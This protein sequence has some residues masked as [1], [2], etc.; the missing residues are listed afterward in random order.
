MV[1][2]CEQVWTEISNYLDGEVEAGLRAAIDEHIHGCT[3]CAAVLEGTR[4]VIQLYGDER[5]SEVPL[6]FGHRLHRRLED[7]M[8]SSRRGFLGWMVAAAAA[9]LLAGTFELARSSPADR[10]PL[11]SEHAESG[12]GVPPDMMVVVATDGK[13]FHRNSRCPFINDKGHLRTIPAH[14][15][16]SE[17]Y[18]PCVRCMK[19]YLAT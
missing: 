2:H 12:R 17:G 6:G 14:E 9:V 19:Q 7:S 11:R 10:L 4:N 16:I 3:R 5:M 15:A 18:T 13:T 1:V 8:A